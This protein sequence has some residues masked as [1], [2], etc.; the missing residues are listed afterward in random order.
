[1][2][3]KSSLSTA[4]RARA[5]RQP[6]TPAQVAEV[7]ALV[8][9]HLDLASACEAVGLTY[10]GLRNAMARDES[11]M[12]AVRKSQALAAHKLITHALASPG[13]DAK[14]PL[15]L[16]ERQQRERYKPPK[17]EV[18]QKNEHSGPGGAPIEVSPPLTLEQ[19]RA[20]LLEEAERVGQVTAEVNRLLGKGDK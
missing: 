14:A 15:W 17:A 13:A 2:P 1:M 3:R 20:R 5:D 6:W 12:V 7:C 8:E 9:D 4:S 19:R 16:L 18:E 11:I 10:D